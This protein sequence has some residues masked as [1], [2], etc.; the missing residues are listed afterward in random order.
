VAVEQVY[1]GAAPVA[2]GRGLVAS[3]FQYYLSG[4]ESLRVTVQAILPGGTVDV[5]WRTW[6]EDDRSIVLTR[7]SIDYGSVVALSTTHEYPLQAGALLNV[8]VG[9][10]SGTGVYGLLWV[11][12]QLLQGRGTA[13]LVVGTL[14]QGY[15][16]NQNDLA[17]PGSPIEKQDQA[18]GSVFS[19]AGSWAPRRSHGP[20]RRVSAGA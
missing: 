1:P 16:S 13:A 2:I 15:V 10:G 11:R 6:R 17:W 18:A 20:C 12:V 5:L 3:S 14:L 8:R 19:I 9:V 4:V 7:E